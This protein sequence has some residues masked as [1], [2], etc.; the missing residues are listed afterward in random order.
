M[1]FVLLVLAV[2]VI[3]SGNPGLEHGIDSLGD[4][5]GSTRFDDEPARSI[6]WQIL[7]SAVGISLFV[8]FACAMAEV[9]HRREGR[10]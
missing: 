2:T 8:M 7:F 10:R 4:F 5:P 3:V 9:R 6:G 1:A